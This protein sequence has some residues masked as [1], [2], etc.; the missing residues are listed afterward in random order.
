[1]A[2]IALARCW[3]WATF[4][5]HL[6]EFV[7]P[8]CPIPF[9]GPALLRFPGHKLTVL[10]DLN[11]DLMKPMT[12]R[13]HQVAGALATF[14]LQD[15]LQHFKQQTNFSHKLTWWQ[16]CRGKIQRARND[17]ILEADRR[18]FQNVSIWD[19]RKFSTDHCMLKAL[20]LLRPTKSHKAYLKGQKAFPLQPPTG[21]NIT[22]A[23]RLF[24][25]LKSYLPPPEPQQE[26]VRSQWLSEK[27]LKLIA[28][29]AQA[30]RSTHATRAQIK[31]LGR[32]LK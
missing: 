13:C 5:D 14:G 6:L 22:P 32:E 24:T 15:M 12:Q 25:T 10:S 2:P 29:K 28:Q 9:A 17:C 30:S 20:L 21:P 31:K 26:R 1:M 7:S 4:A 23:D 8:L 27:T 18:L 3:S 11:V 19:P 16:K